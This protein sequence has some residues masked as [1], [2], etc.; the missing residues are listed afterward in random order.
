M[1]TKPRA[2]QRAESK[3]APIDLLITRALTQ[4]GEHAEDFALQSGLMREL[5]VDLVE[6]LVAS[7]L[8][9]ARMV[10]AEWR[11]DVVDE[12]S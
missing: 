9:T 2:W 10:G 11:D 1:S 6:D 5:G 4:G 12:A 7:A 3:R 8:A